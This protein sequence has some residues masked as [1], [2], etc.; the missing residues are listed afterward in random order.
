LAVDPQFGHR[1]DQ[2]AG[3]GRNLFESGAPRP[4]SGQY[5]NR[6]SS[7]VLIISNH[8][9]I[10]DDDDYN[11]DSDCSGAGV[12]EASDRSNSALDLR[13]SGMSLNIP[14]PVATSHRR[15]RQSVGS[16]R[17]ANKRRPKSVKLCVPGS[18][19]FYSNVSSIENSA[20]GH[21][22]ETPTS[23]TG[24]ETETSSNCP[25]GNEESSDRSSQL[26]TS[27]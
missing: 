4:L 6:A 15:H 26:V 12:G 18:P 14:P 9:S 23:I 17:E 25:N 16:V 27:F 11:G 8:N 1:R 21:Q 10:Y 13:A 3:G 22:P 7:P 20:T 24:P 19:G 5:T 2:S